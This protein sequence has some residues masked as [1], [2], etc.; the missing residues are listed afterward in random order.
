M[1][2]IFVPMLVELGIHPALTQ[3]AY[4]IADSSTNII[5][6]LMTYFA[7]VVIFMQKNDEYVGMGTLISTMLPYSMSFLL[8]WTILLIIWILLGIPVGPGAGLFL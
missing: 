8:S 4:R 1:A 6:P 7:M 2:P 3:V 5:S